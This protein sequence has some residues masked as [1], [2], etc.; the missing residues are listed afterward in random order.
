MNA[1]RPGMPAIPLS[2]ALLLLAGSARAETNWRVDYGKALEEAKQSGK[3]I[4]VVVGTDNCHW[5][6][7]LDSRTLAVPEV[8]KL[9]N[10]RFVPFKLDADSQPELARALKVQMYPSLFIASPTGSIVAYQEGFLEAGPLKEKLVQAL[11]AVGTPDWMAN[12]YEAGARAAREGNQARALTL[13]RQ[14]VE[15]GKDRPVQAKARRLIADLERDARL[16]EAKARELADSGKTE[17]AL[18]ELKKLDRSFPGTPAARDGRQLMLRLMSRGESGDREQASAA[19][20]LLEQAKKD[21]A[22]RQYLACLDRCDLLAS[23]YANLPEAAEADKLAREI[24]AS[25]EWTKEAADQL[26][27]RLAGMYLSLA[28]TYTKKG[29]PEQ[30]T[31][32]L[33]RV[34]S[35][36]PSSR[37]AEI[38]RQ[39]LARMKGAP[40]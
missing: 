9:V 18:A 14:V 23:R 5:C 13:L 40:K 29:E 17:L 20:E 38:A 10:G 35:V 34:V 31:A 15:D 25:P 27:V 24:R 21:H 32:Y 39:Q 30:A 11:A 33:E 37:Q 8:E 12:A 16:Q 1:T 28:E 26:E 2:L 3:P 7:Q 19:R 4:L 22:S 6:K 36:A